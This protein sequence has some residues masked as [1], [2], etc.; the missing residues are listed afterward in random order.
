MSASPPRRLLA[1][2]VIVCAITF[3]LLGAGGASGRSE[4]SPS[5]SQEPSISG[6]PIVGHT[7]KGNRGKWTGTAPLTYSGVWLRCD[8]NAQSC[9]AISGAT[10]QEY[11][12][13]GADVVST[14][15]FLV[16]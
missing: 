9:N 13:I 15:R 14:L 10:T 12:I 8:E 7:L 6:T 16:T 5:L 4:A 2:A 1:F 11:T 3:S